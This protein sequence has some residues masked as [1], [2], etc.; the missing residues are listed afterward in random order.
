ML[1]QASGGFGHQGEGPHGRPVAVGNRR[2]NAARD[3]IGSERQA[4]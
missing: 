3:A 1:E 2:A 4:Q